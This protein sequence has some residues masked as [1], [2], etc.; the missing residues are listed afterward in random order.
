MFEYQC[1]SV[2]WI[3]EAKAF[4]QEH[5]ST[6]YRLHTFLVTPASESYPSGYDIVMEREVKS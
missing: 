2:V 4:M 5:A 1:T 3:S 6:G